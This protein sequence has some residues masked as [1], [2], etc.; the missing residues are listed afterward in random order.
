MIP[1]T[2]VNIV[3]N[4]VPQA[5][6]IHHPAAAPGPL[7]LGTIPATIVSMIP[8][9]RLLELTL[10]DA[11]H[12]YADVIPGP[13]GAVLATLVQLETPVTVRA[14]AR[15]SNV[16]AQAALD[17]VN[18]LV[19]AGI[20][21]ADQAGSALMV[22]LN[23]DHL[24]ADAVTALVELRGRLVE[25]LTSDL[26]TWDRLAGAWLFGSMARGDGTRDADIDLLLVTDT[27]I[28]NPAWV[29]A[30][31][32]LRD[33]VRAWT[34]NEGQFVEHTRRSFTRLVELGNPLIAALV[35]EGIPL[36]PESRQMIRGAA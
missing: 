34:G 16:S 25:K 9:T 4:Q 31:A 23:R 11:A 6:T 29:D 32:G 8:D 15:H 1:H 30:T 20:V 3:T 22:S 12:P 28:D 2:M 35:A 24:A 33:R 21:V 7:Q 13:R 18:E 26:T 36:T 14:L 27:E 10:V 19:D 17:H 5:V